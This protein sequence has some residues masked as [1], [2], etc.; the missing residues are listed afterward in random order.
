MRRRAREISPP[1]P[2]SRKDS[3][4]GKETMNRPVLKRHANNAHTNPIYHKQIEREELHEELRIM[5][6][7][8]IH[9]QT[10]QGTLEITKY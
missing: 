9:Q 5:L 7:K 6:N 10:P 3:I 2:T 4:P 1:I 8:A